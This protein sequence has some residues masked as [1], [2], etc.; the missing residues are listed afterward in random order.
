MTAERGDDLGAHR[1][2]RGVQRK[3]QPDVRVGIDHHRNRTEGFGQGFAPGLPA[4]RGHEHQPSPGD[5][6][7]SFQ[8]SQYL[9][10]GRKIR[11]GDRAGPRPPPCWVMTISADGTDS[12]CSAAAAAAV[13]ARCSA[14]ILAI[15]CRLASSGN[16]HRDP[17]CA[18]RPRDGRSGYD[19]RRPAAH[20]RVRWSCLP[21]PEPPPDFPVQDVVERRQQLRNQ[22]RLTATVRSP[23]A[24]RPDEDRTVPEPAPRC[25]CAV[26]CGQSA[27]GVLGFRQPHG[28]RRDL[29][30][31]GPG[32]H[33]Q[34]NVSQRIPRNRSRSDPR[35]QRRRA[36]K[37]V[38]S[39]C[40]AWR[41]RRANPTR[42]TPE[43]R[44]T[45]PKTIHHVKFDRSTRELQ[46]PRRH[47]RFQVDKH[48]CSPFF[49]QERSTEC[50][51][52]FSPTFR[53]RTPPQEPE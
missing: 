10:N 12:R 15:I 47:H 35:R 16:S 20:P 18:D 14:A 34:L 41:K 27:T 36:G 29:D 5:V 42:I 3:Q 6:E 4:V 48:V 30:R 31:L 28:D 24:I 53:Q 13:G 8:R 37:V 49:C 2:V 26:R 25:R 33:D 22:L 52:T 21:A 32:A 40:P 51:S 23:T 9:V 1:G 45:T 43:T 38:V 11:G 17:R 7:F 46:H 44:L 50:A 39:C 19:A